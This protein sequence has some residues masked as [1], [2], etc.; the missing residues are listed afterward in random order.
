[1]NDR[2][3]LNAITGASN[4]FGLKCKKFTGAFTVEIVRYVLAGEGF[5][6]SGRDVYIRGIPIEIDLLIA[7]QGVTPER[8]ILFNKEDSMVALEIKSRG[9]FGEASIKSIAR[10]FNAIREASRGTRCIYLTIS[11]RESY[12]Y[13]ATK[14]NIGASVYTLFWHS[15]PEENLKF[16]PTGDWER[17]IQELRQIQNAG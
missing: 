5:N 16:M 14:E 15:G 10:N 7:R 13:K 2:E 3:I 9:T 6:V 1:M 17:F 4:E 8:G 11:D 12:K